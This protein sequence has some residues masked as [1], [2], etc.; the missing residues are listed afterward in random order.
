MHLAFNQ[1]I[2]TWNVSSVTDMSGMFEIASAFNQD[3]GSWNVSNVTNMNR[4]FMMQ[5]HLIKI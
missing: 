1:D 4:C 5:P 3:I 2:S